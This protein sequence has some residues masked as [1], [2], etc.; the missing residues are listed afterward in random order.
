MVVLDSDHSPEHVE[1]EIDLYG[2][3]VSSGCYLVVEDDIQQWMTNFNGQ[4]P[5]DAIEFRL[6]DRPEWERDLL[7]ESMYAITMHPAGWWRHA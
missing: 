1:R 7:V 4:G 6:M 5:L 3:L 2:P